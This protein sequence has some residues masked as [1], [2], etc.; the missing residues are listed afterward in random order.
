MTLMT[1]RHRLLL[2]LLLFA[3]HVTGCRTAPPAPDEHPIGGLVPPPARPDSVNLAELPQPKSALLPRLTDAVGLSTPQ[4]RARR[5]VRKDLRAAV[6][7]SIGKGGVYAP[8]ALKVVSSYK[9]RAAVINA[10]SGA[11]VTAIGKN[12]APAATAAGATA[13]A[14]TKEAASWKV[15]ALWIGV[16]G[17]ALAL[18]Y[19]AAPVLAWLPSRQRLLGWAGYR[20]KKQAD[21]PA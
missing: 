20:E 7:H 6:P 1:P 13:T 12:K 14:T 15:W 18:W 5:Q 9:S 4:G 16:V 21:N 10:D 11:T 2:L 17:G 3:A 19:L 8:Q